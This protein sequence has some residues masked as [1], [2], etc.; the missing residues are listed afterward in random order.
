MQTSGLG[1][2]QG[3]SH[4]LPADAVD[5]DIHLN[6]SN[7]I[8]GTGNLKIHIADMIFVTKDITQNDKLVTLLHQSHG[9]SGNRC[10]D[11][12]PGI[13]QGQ[14]TTTNRSHRR[15]AVRLSNV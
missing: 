15:R 9:D 7:T 2:G 11:R 8:F 3:F 5:L 10:F 14:T 12:H 1:L 6:S 13:H 4:D